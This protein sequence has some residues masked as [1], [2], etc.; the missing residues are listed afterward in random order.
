MAWRTAVLEAEADC[1]T[2]GDYVKFL[3]DMKSKSIAKNVNVRIHYGKIIV[4]LYET[5]I[6]IFYKDGTFTADNGQGEFAS[7][8]TTDRLKQFGPKN[9][10]FFHRNGVLFCEFRGGCDHNTRYPVAVRGRP[11]T[12]LSQQ[13]LSALALA[14][15]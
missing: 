12:E 10:N 15:A 5:D 3:G 8:T 4:R 1:R 11:N 13:K 9:L 7:V 2:Y 14:A 6:L